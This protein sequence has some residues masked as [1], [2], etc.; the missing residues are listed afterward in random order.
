MKMNSRNMRL[1]S[2]LCFTFLTS[3]CFASENDQTI[4]PIFIQIEPVEIVM[5]CPDDS[6]HEGELIP[7]WVTSDEA[8]EFFCNDSDELELA[9]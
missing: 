4:E 3:I 2:A 6:Q 7:K 5:L 8:T 9:E 1:L